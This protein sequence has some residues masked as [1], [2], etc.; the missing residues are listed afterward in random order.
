MR[1]SIPLRVL[2]GVDRVAALCAPPTPPDAEALKA[3]ARRKTR[4][5][6]FGEDEPYDEPLQRLLEAC[7]READLNLFGRLSLR[8]DMLRLLGNRLILRD[9][10]R[11]DPT[12]LERPVTAPIVVMG[13]PR[14]GTSFLHQLLAQDPAALTP[15]CWR[16][17]FPCPT[18]PAAGRSAG[19]D[20]VQ[21]QFSL[22]QRL[23]PEIVGLHPF[24]ARTPQECTEIT[25][26]SFR[27]LRFE[28]TY[29]IPS[30]RDWLARADHGPA[31]RMHRRFLQHLQGGSAG[32]W[33][34]KS[35]D[36]VFALDALHATYPDARIVFVHR[37]PLKVL[38]SVA[39]L[40]AVLRR[41]FS[42]RID[43]AGVGRQV[44][45]DWARGAGLVIEA[46]RRNLWPERQV[47]HLRY[48]DLVRDPMAAL[49]RLY[50]H[51]LIPGSAEFERRA[52]EL[53]DSKPRGGY[54]L[55]VYRLEDHGLSAEA[56]RFRFRD[57]MAAFDVEPEIGAPSRLGIRRT[58]ATRLGSTALTA[59]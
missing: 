9:C 2:Q 41:P 37:D 59:K 51:F 12:I 27:S 4:L 39:R 32:R 44:A 29:D 21:R 20:Q 7:A 46:T 48:T 28:T 23:Q 14:S 19:P 35:P 34:L 25:A 13:L 24:D 22:F 58:Q 54:G 10:E 18:H 1:D 6:D 11:A 50:D 47:L 26:H 38:P 15:Q 42:R 55:N 5:E 17:I 53:V 49:R 43:M 33:V 36:H 3:Q 45:R 52:H 8:W 40:T 57:Y 31:Y 16:T 56:E 30:Y